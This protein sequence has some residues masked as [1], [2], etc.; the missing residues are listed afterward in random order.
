[1]VFKLE[2]TESLKSNKLWNKN[3]LLLWQGQLVSCLGDALYSIALGFW[4][5]DKTGSSTIMGILMAAVS[6]PRIILGPFAGVIVDRFN[7]KKLILLG[8][9]IRGLGMLFVGYAAYNNSLEVWMVMVVGIICGICSAFF[10]P[11][12]SSVIPDLVSSEN[13][14]KANSAQQMAT[15]TT[16]LL[17][18]MSGGFIYSIL[19]A[20][21]MFILNGISYIVS[22][23]TE[24]FIDIPKVERKNDNLTF[25]E[26]FKEG[27]RFTFGFR[28]LVI[29][30]STAFILNFFYAMF[31]ILQKPLFNI[32]PSLGVARYGVLTAFQSIGMIVAS[33]FLT[34]V[35]IKTENRA[36]VALSSLFI[37]SII[38][39][40][41]VSTKNF[42][43][44]CIC[45]FMGL[46]L[47]TVGN[48]V[49][50]SSMMV[51]IP[52]ELRGKV[53]SIVMTFS[54]G[55]HPI[56]TLIGGVLGDIFYPRNIMIACFIICIVVTIPVVLS[57]SARKV[58][59]YNPEIQSLDD[60]KS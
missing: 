20:S 10:N 60:I 1:M 35:N 49:M 25:K 15:S 42:T 32:D 36:K 12:I 5:L 48:T 22:T 34:K 6:L 47:N 50:M 46:F 19:G 29:L 45:F 14:V 27:I 21:V 23:V 11:A 33:V 58:L 8:D 43:V 39:L 16:N 13:I 18:S 55:I 4:V 24:V 57:K 41:G 56:G 26:D 54:M 37:Q 28:G 7:R 38:L 52:Q 3:F 59:N 9:F 30:L 31:S 53:L 44:M 51:T 40:I 2:S 17:G